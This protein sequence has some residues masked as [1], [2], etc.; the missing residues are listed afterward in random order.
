MA[1]IETIDEAINDLK[2]VV[3]GL[4]RNAANL[5]QCIQNIEVAKN[6]ESLEYLSILVKQ[7]LTYRLD[8]KAA[9]KAVE[10]LEANSWGQLNAA[11]SQQMEEESQ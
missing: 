8:Y 3:M 7:I 4:H 9:H 2:Q 5:D 11:I 10:R 1:K 6:N